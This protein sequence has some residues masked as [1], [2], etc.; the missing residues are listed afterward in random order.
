MVEAALKTLMLKRLFPR[1]IFKE[2]FLDASAGATAVR[3]PLIKR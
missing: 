2:E 1:D 3:S